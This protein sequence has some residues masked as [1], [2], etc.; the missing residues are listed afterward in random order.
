MC[1]AQIETRVEA[2]YPALDGVLHPDPS[3]AARAQL[4]ELVLGYAAKSDWV[5]LLFVLDAGELT[6]LD[7]TFK[8]GD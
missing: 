5:H 8:L 7:T 6:L 2:A 1:S 4:E 3:P